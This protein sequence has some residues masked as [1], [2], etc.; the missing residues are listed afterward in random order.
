MI[1][2]NTDSKLGAVVVSCVII[3][4]KNCC[5]V[6]SLPVNFHTHHKRIGLCP[7]PILASKNTNQRS[8]TMHA[9]LISMEFGIDGTMCICIQNEIELRDKGVWKW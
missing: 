1:N 6:I 7:A 4:I 5:E 3:D 2:W 9:F 8:H